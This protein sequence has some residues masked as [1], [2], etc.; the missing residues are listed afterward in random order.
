MRK[1]VLSPDSKLGKYSH[2]LLVSYDGTDYYGWQLQDH[3]PT[4]QGAMESALSMVTREDRVVLG[5]CGAGRTDSGVHA[6][7]QVVQ[8]Y[9]NTEPDT[10]TLAHRLNSLLSDDVRVH[11]AWRTAPDFS[12]TCTALTKTYHYHM[13]TTRIHNPFTLRY[14]HHQR[15]AL[16]VGVM[17]R[18]AACMVGVHDFTQ[19]SNQ[20]DQRLKRNP[21]KLLQRVDVVEAEDGLRVEVQGTGFLYKMVR[22]LTGVLIAVGEGVLPVETV[23][24]R[25]KVGNST[26]PGGVGGLWRGY[27][28]APAKGLIL[29]QVVYP[30]SADDPSTLLYPTQPHDSFGRLIGRLPGR[31]VEGDDDE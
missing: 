7:G 28:I 29:H 15:Q 18:A 23:T 10:S 8:F 21:V 2:R 5:V 27:N 31:P 3:F 11:A 30:A 19:F 17:R 22:H 25:L 9:T 20:N 13:H 4:V 16:D 6:A 1:Q 14:R 26:I 12:V 24:E